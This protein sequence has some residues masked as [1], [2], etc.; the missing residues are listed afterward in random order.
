[1]QHSLFYSFRNFNGNY[2]L[3]KEITTN[4]KY[5]QLTSTDA[6]IIDVLGA[7]IIL[8]VNRLHQGLYF[9]LEFIKSL[10]SK[11]FN[12]HYLTIIIRPVH[13]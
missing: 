5:D 10:T 4:E 2:S 1:M 8:F 7:R 12:I 13:S 11:V 6:E 3:I 9:N